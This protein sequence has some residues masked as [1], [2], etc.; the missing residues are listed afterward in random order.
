MF[1]LSFFLHRFTIALVFAAA[2]V[3]VCCE[4]KVN[5]QNGESKFAW[6]FPEK[7]YVNDVHVG[8]LQKDVLRYPYCSSVASRT[9]IRF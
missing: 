4:A 6:H 5:N 7:F 1:G 9:I 3:F 2:G 8:V